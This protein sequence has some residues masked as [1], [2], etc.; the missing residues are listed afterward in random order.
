MKLFAPYNR[1]STM[2]FLF[3]ALVAATF[4]TAFESRFGRLGL[5][6][7]IAAMCATGV[8]GAWLLPFHNRRPVVDYTTICAAVFE[9]CKSKARWITLHLET[10]V[11][12]AE[13][14]ADHQFRV[15]SRDQANDLIA[16][17][18]RFRDHAWPEEP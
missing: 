7:S 8:L 15:L 16:L 4:W 2:L 14:D 5:G 3:Y 13:S 18:E 9:N 6:I 11:D 12:R 10:R 1:R 17:L